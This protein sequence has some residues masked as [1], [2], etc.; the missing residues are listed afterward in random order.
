[1]ESAPANPAQIARQQ[2]SFVKKHRTFMEMILLA[3]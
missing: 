2:A 1:M 3:K